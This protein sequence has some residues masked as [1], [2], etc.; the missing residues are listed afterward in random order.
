MPFLCNLQNTFMQI[1]FIISTGVGKNIDN[2]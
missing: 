1:M 2:A